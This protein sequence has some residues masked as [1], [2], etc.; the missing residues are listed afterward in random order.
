MFE[1]YIEFPDYLIY[2]FAKKFYF[3]PFDFYKVA[4]LIGIASFIYGVSLLIRMDDISIC[5]LIKIVL[6]G[7][8]TVLLVLFKIVVEEDRAEI[9][10]FYKTVKDKITMTT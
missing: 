4:K 5:I 1:V 2:I 7:I 10:T 9:R 3:I 6:L 8:F